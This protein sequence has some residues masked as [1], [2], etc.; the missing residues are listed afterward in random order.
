MHALQLTPVKG[1]RV[2]ARGHVD[3]TADGVVEDRRFYLV[4]E[5][6]RMVNGKQLG[7]LNEVVADYDHGART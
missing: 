6:G 2:A 3:V 1:L 4:D 5:R 7:M